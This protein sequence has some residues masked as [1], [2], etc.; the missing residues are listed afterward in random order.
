MASQFA[1]LSQQTFDWFL[2]SDARAYP[3]L[4]EF[5]L[6]RARRFR[7][8]TDAEDLS[9]ALLLDVLRLRERGALPSRTVSELEAYLTVS[10]QR[11]CV[12]SWRKRAS[13]RHDGD[14]EAVQSGADGPDGPLR[15]LQHVD[16]CITLMRHALDHV[17][18]GEKFWPVVQR[19]LDRFML[20][21][22]VE[23]VL[24]DRGLLRAGA[25]AEERAVERNNE[26]RRQ[27]RARVALID[28]LHRLSESTRSSCTPSFVRAEAR[29]IPFD[30]DDVESALRFA[31]ALGRSERSETSTRMKE[32]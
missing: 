15:G 32:Q 22:H 19:I 21:R 9:Q 23:T 7:A 30:A 2:A 16:L 28:A 4:S 13:R 24:V 27:S 17:E 26:N 11:R 3:P 10:M 5:L 14:L 12:S 1:A 8:T 25:S 18:G 20:G 6:S 31:L 29:Q